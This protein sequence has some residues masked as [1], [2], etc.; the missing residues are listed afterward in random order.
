VNE[1]TNR[2]RDYIDPKSGTEP[3]DKFGKSLG[4]TVYKAYSCEFGWHK[5]RP[6]PDDP[7][8]LVLTVR[9]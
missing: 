6:V 7:L 8:R 5:S 2:G 3:T 1:R 9:R 4:V